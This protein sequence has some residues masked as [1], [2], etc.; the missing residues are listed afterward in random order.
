MKKIAAIFL[1]IISAYSVQAQSDSTWKFK[2]L[3]SVN[4]ELFGPA[5]LYSVNCGKIILNAKRFK[6][7]G[8]IGASYFPNSKFDNG[9]SFQT[10][11]YL[12]ELFSMD[13]NNHIELGVG[14]KF[15][16]AK[17]ELYNTPFFRIGFRHQNPNR[18][19]IYKLT[20]IPSVEKSTL[21]ILNPD[22]SSTNYQLTFWVGFSF[23]Y[24]F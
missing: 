20:I 23:G 12:S 18:K 2:K 6:T 4:I 9:A 8:N 16:F 5:V 11:I 13:K 17:N 1:I 10:P 15:F 14:N 21:A 7:I 22:G 19:F 3:N 24:A